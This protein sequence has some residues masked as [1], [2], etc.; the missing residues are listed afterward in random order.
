MSEY[1]K[2]TS[3]HKTVPCDM[4]E[5]AASFKDH[6]HWI[7]GKDTI[8]GVLISTV[9]LGMDHNWGGGYP[10]LFETMIFGGERDQYQERCS[11]WDEAV[12]MHEAAVRLV[13]S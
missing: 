9:F 13:R 2:L 1:Y 10:L 12:K 5:W 3:D 6:E 11:T 7:V 4:M 8:D